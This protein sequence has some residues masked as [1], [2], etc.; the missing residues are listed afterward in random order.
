MSD[1]YVVK[2]ALWDWGIW[3][4]QTNTW[5]IRGNLDHNEAKTRVKKTK[6]LK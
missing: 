5:V 3:D 4:T 2:K 6:W 1:R